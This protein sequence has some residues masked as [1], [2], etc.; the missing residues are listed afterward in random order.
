MGVARQV[1][2]GYEIAV[3]AAKRPDTKMTMLK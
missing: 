2:A 1:D 3:Q